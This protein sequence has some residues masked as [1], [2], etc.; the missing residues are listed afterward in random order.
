[1]SQLNILEKLNNRVFLVAGDASPRKFYRYKKN[2]KQILVYCEKDKKNNLENYIKVNNFLIKN[3]IKAPR[4]IKEDIK[5]N[6]IIIEDLGD[7]LLKKVVQNKKNKFHDF[8][9]IINEL[10]KLQ[11][12]KVKKNLPFYSLKFLKEELNL[13]YKWYLPEFF[14]NK[15][16]TRI[17][18]EIDSVL[19]N[20]L[21]KTLRFNN[22]FVHR[23]FHVENLILYKKRI[24]FIDNQDA[25][26]GHPAY[27]LMSLIDDVRIKIKISDQIK[28][29][30]YY[31]NQ[32]KR[33]N[34]SFDFHFHVLSVQRSL[35][36]LGIF[37][38]LYKRDNKKKYLK[39]LKRTWQLIDLRLKHNKLSSLRLI[40][41]KYFSKKIKNKKW[42]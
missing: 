4:T 24:G 29:Y 42:K 9:K 18:K 10:V 28:L 8:K 27:D 32:S 13:F 33:I 40:F 5:K 12:I 35:K 23:D 14:S 7:K 38:R 37:L 22:V 3:K 41:N 30:N 16:I 39:Y 17:K 1:M 11:N 21:K 26:I 34:K 15:Q 36:I 25:V 20:H 6:Y 19:I 2:K 31:L